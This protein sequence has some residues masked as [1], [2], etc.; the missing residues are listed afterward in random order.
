MIVLYRSPKH[1]AVQVYNE[2]RP[3]T[4]VQGHMIMKKRKITTLIENRDLGI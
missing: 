1:I 3:N 2:D 4:K